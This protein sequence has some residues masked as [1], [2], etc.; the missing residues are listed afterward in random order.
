ML[1]HCGACALVP[2]IA[3]RARADTRISLAISMPSA[4]LEHVE[5]GVEGRHDV[6]RVRLDA[7]VR[8]AGHGALELRL[9]EEA[10]GGVGL[11]LG[12]GLG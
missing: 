2:L 4:R 1:T 11:G 6:A 7:G 3:H 10:W 9:G 5:V 12:L 8:E